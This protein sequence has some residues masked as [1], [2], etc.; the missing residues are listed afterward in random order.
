MTAYVCYN[1]I[2]KLVNNADSSTVHVLALVAAHEVGHLLISSNAHSPIGIM[3]PLWPAKDLGCLRSAFLLFHPC[4]I[5]IDD[6][7]SPPAD[8][9]RER[10]LDAGGASEAGR[11][12]PGAESSRLTAQSDAAEPEGQ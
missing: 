5:K 7:A 10:G 1:H 11:G 8:G 2:R 12:R 3:R 9:A 6:R 4:R